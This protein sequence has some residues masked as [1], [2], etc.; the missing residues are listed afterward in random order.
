M[1]Y[2]N[3]ANETFP[4]TTTGVPTNLPSNDMATPFGYST[5]AIVVPSDEYEKAR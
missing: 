1:L 2:S 4:S 5:P 3:G